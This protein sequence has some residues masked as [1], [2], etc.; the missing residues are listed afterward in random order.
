LICATKCVNICHMEITDGLTINIPYKVA[1]T[2]ETVYVPT[3]AK[4][5]VDECQQEINKW[6]AV[7]SRIE[8]G[9]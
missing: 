2:G 4:D 1:E 3:N 6:A 7:I 9:L 5:A 8:A